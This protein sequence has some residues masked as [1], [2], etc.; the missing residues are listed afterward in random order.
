MGYF[1][2]PPGISHPGESPTQRSSELYNLPHSI[3][4][5][6]RL[7]PLARAGSVERAQRQLRPAI[8]QCVRRDVT[9][10]DRSGTDHDIVAD[11][12]ALADEHVGG[13]PDIVA[14][15][16]GCRLQ[17]LPTERYI[18]SGKDMVMQGNRAKHAFS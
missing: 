9:R 10:H 17:A 16:D 13:D 14:D 15:P 8:G 11:I 4:G 3:G 2:M 12:H 18:G 1:L 7:A 5:L 6:T